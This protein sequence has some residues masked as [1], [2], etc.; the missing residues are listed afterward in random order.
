MHIPDDAQDQLY[1]AMDALKPALPARRIE[2]LAAAALA[3]VRGWER[4]APRL[5]QPIEIS[6][7][8]VHDERFRMAVVVNHEDEPYVIIHGLEYAMREVLRELRAKAGE[9]S[10]P[11]TNP[12]LS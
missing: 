8:W 1:T 2:E 10:P 5:P 11:V 4:P 3:V 7:P 6:G 9:P 12:P